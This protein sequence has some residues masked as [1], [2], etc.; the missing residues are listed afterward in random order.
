MGGVMWMTVALHLRP[1]FPGDEQPGHDRDRDQKPGQDK[2]VHSQRAERDSPLSDT[3]M[4]FFLIFPFESVISGKMKDA[5]RNCAVRMK[6]YDH[7]Q[8]FHDDGG[9]DGIGRIREGAGKQ[10]S[11]EAV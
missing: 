10:G 6:D 4:G 2:L 1:R 3:G 5:R 9:G 8:A 7:T 11:K